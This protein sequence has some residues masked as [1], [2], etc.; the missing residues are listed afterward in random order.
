[1]LSLDDELNELVNQNKEEPKVEFPWFYVNLCKLKEPVVYKPFVDASGVPFRMIT[2]LRQG[3]IDDLDLTIR[4]PDKSNFKSLTAS[5]AT[6]VDELHKNL[7]IYCNNHPDSW[8][9][10]P[11]KS[12]IVSFVSLIKLGDV[13]YNVY[14]PQVMVV[15]SARYIGF[16]KSFIG[17]LTKLGGKD[18]V[19]TVFS[20]DTHFKHAI[21]ATAKRVEERGYEFSFNLED[22][23]E[24]DIPQET[25]DRFDNL[26]YEYVDVE[27]FNEEH[28]EKALK[29]LIEVNGK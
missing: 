21:K 1:M 18:L 15:N 23:Y 10:K 12:T 29:G 5:Q 9:F 26:N 19:N 13:R 8:A 7:D 17:E 24:D 28:Y 16:F 6:L 25:I 20:R 4:L 22:S 11:T 27:N 14:K 3:T 2:G